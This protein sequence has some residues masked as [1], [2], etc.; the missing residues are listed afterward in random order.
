[1]GSIQPAP[2]EGRRSAVG[3]ARC[4][5]GRRMADSGEM[6]FLPL[7]PVAKNCAPSDPERLRETGRGILLGGGFWVTCLCVGENPTSPSS[8]SSEPGRETVRLSGEG[9]GLALGPRGRRVGS[10]G[11]ARDVVSATCGSMVVAVTS[12]LSCWS[13]DIFTEVA[14]DRHSDFGLFKKLKTCDARRTGRSDPVKSSSSLLDTGEGLRSA[15]RKSLPKLR[16]P[17]SD[18]AS[19]CSELLGY[20]PSVESYDSSSES[21]GGREE[22][23]DDGLSW[24]VRAGDHPGTLKVSSCPPLGGGVLHRGMGGGRALVDQNR[25]SLYV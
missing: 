3:E 25:V 17:P 13:S 20:M 23:V 19:T 11:K 24:T 22:R 21:G 8:S 7:V 14:E 1:M 5:S 9:L 18:P 16:S 2:L 15:G 4:G 12:A 10:A 6:L